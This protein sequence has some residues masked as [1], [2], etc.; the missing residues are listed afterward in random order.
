MQMMGQRGVPISVAGV[1]FSPGSWV[2]ADN[3]SLQSF[4]Q[5]NQIIIIFTHHLLLISN[6]RLE[7]LSVSKI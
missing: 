1:M 7:L 2:Y 4:Q 3:V 5:S 6:L